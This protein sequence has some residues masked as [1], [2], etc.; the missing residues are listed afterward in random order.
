MGFPSEFNPYLLISL[1][2]IKERMCSHGF[3]LL[4]HLTLLF[5]C[6]FRKDIPY[7]PWKSQEPDTGQPHTRLILE[8]PPDLDLYAP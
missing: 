6:V 8:D 1:V 7:F 4:S 3:K 2:I 5:L